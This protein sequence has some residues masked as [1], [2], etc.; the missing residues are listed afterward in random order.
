MDKTYEKC[1]ICDDGHLVPI[2]HAMEIR[3]RNISDQIDGFQHSE[4]NHCGAEITDAPQSRANK[5]LV[6]A[7]HKRV[8][9]VRPA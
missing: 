7:F 8:E 4:C 1:P 6:I 9:K 5:H 2:R 3:Y